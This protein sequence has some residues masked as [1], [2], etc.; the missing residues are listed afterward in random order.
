VESSVKRTMR[1]VTPNR[2]GE[3]A[4]HM[5]N[6]EAETLKTVWMWRSI[7][8]HLNGLDAHIKQ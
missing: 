8:G 7:A 5:G 1:I 6:A 3:G 4:F 2:L